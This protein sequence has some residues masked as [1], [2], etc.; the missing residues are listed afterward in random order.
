MAVRF[1]D[2][3]EVRPDKVNWLWPNRIPYGE[4]TLLVGEPQA[5]K[6]TLTCYIISNVTQ[7][8]PMY[9]CT[10]TPSPQGVLLIAGEDRLDT[11][12]KPRLITAGAATR[13]IRALDCTSDFL[14]LPSDLPLIERQLADIQGKLIII[15]PLM[16]F[17]EGN[18]N[19][20]QSMRKSLG[21]LAALARR[22]GAAVLL[23][24]HLTKSGR[25]SALYQSAG[26]I[27]IVGLV[28][29]ALLAAKLPGGT[30]QRVLAHFKSNLGPLARSL[31]FRTIDQ[32]GIPIIEWLGEVACSADELAALKGPEEGSALAEAI[33]V[34]FSILGEK[35]LDAK[36]AKKLAGDAGVAP[37]TLKRA[38]KALGVVSRREGFGPESTFYWELH[39]DNLLVQNLREDELTN[40]MG[41]L[42]QGD[43]DPGLGDWWKRKC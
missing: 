17:V 43:N 34:L 22:T 18:A 12:L 27:G 4:L 28:R 38:K 32:A 7:G 29:S 23:V 24:H 41:R 19:S 36:S 39:E 35:K 37:A 8:R 26:S 1:V 3:E 25:G 42:V 10:G 20:D 9:N 33:Y 40:L 31:S 6:S 13:R 5:G 11:T 30:D 14:R 2:L 16:Q 15:D 21:P